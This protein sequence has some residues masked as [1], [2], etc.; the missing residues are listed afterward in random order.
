MIKG[1]FDI[2][3]LSQSLIYIA[4][5]HRLM[6]ELDQL[7]SPDGVIFIHILNTSIR[8]ATLLLGDQV[9]Y[10]TPDSLNCL[11]ASF[12]FAVRIVNTPIFSKDIIAVVTRQDDRRKAGSGTSHSLS[13][14]PD[15]DDALSS[16]ENLAHDILATVPAEPVSIFGTTIEAGFAH[17]LI[18][19]RVTCFVDENPHKQERL[20]CGKKVLPPSSLP[21]D[22]TCIV[23]MGI[24]SAQLVKRLSAQYQGRFLLL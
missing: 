14:H 23:P 9:F 22:S 6:E 21:K 2:I 16:L 24:N 7:L 13:K 10:F 3:L 5:L 20:F 11:L 8:P 4:D 18:H 1:V 15:A 12:G 17:S 19:H